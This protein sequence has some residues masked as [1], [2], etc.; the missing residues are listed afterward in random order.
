MKRLFGRI[1]RKKGFQFHKADLREWTEAVPN[2]ARGW[3]QIY[4]FEVHTEPG[5][6][7]LEGC[8]DPDDSLVLLI[9]DIGAYRDRDL[10]EDCFLHMHKILDFFEKRSFDMIVRVVYD[11]EGKGLEREPSSFSRVQRHLT[12]LGEWFAGCSEAV[13]L[14]QGMLIGSW[15]EMHTS[16]FLAH[17]KLQQMAEILR[18]HRRPGMYLAVRRPVQW[19]CLHDCEGDFQIRKAPYDG[20]GLFDDGMFGSKT[21][22]GTFGAGQSGKV[23]W[24]DAWNPGE[25]LDFEEALCR[26]VPNGGEAVSGE[27][28]FPSCEKV[29]ETLGRMHVTYLNRAH[30]R[31]LLEQWK[32]QTV[33]WAGPWAGRSLY[34]YVGAHLGYRFL[35]RKVTV[36]RAEEGMCF[37][38]IGIE[39]T[40]FANCYQE[41]EV[42]LV[43]MDKLGNMGE[44]LL[45]CD[46]RTWERGRVETVGSFLKVLDCELFLAA[47]RKWD[48][49]CIRFA[50]RSDE[51]GRA[52]LGSLCL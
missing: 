6:K 30:D 11:H 47:R 23:G 46:I 51:Q 52:V 39:N 9:L 33:A 24:H 10:E 13:F 17:D 32:K 34:E 37:V 5:F 50:N 16:R 48:G 14:W 22:L 8:L 31:R 43:W 1:D 27:D 18:S 19:R 21:H 7:E 4:T 36:T 45:D 49:A 40:G 42:F 12:Q 44:I 20:M 41:A 29:I 38:E 3:Y 26:F 2:P 25:E 15:G 28:G 35:I